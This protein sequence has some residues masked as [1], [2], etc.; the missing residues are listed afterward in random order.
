MKKIF[1][2]S[3]FLTL[4]FAACNNDSNS[5]EHQYSALFEK[6]YAEL[7]N[8]ERYK[9]YMERYKLLIALS[10]EVNQA[11]KITIGSEEAVDTLCFIP[12]TEEDLQMDKELDLKMAGKNEAM[13]FSSYI[14]LSKDVNATI[15]AEGFSQ[16]SSSLAS[17]RDEPELHLLSNMLERSEY[18]TS[19]KADSAEIYN[20]FCKHLILMDRV[21]NSRYILILKELVNVSAGYEEEN[22]DEFESGVYAGMVYVYDIEKKKFIN[23]LPIGG[24][25]SDTVEGKQSSIEFSINSDLNANIEK[26]IKQGLEEKFGLR[27]EVT[28]F[29]KP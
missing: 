8:S 22:G 18:I 17:F 9:T 15:I 1:V 7:G 3:L 12:P 28:G 2:Y 16:N 29:Y 24:A 25:N 11:D 19:T 14:N 13:P 20:S 26:G 4:P 5:L 6:E 27:G 21:N 23:A 10:E